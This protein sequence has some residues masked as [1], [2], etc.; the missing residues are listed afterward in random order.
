MTNVGI[1]FKRE[2][3]SYFS[4]PL[5]AIFIVIFLALSGVMTFYLGDFFNRGQ[6]D[7]QP[8]FFF[9]PWLYLFLIPAVT[10]RLWAEERKS[11]TIELLL[12]LPITT[13]DAVLGKFL[14]AW[15]FASCAMLLTFPLWLSVNYLGSPDNGAILAGYLGSLLMAGA[16]LAVGSF[17]SAF[18]KNQIIAFVLTTAA[19]FFFTAT[20]SSTFIGF[21]G[22]WAPN[23]FVDVLSGFSFITHFN[24]ISR[25]VLD[26][27][28][29]F[30]FITI[31]LAF[32]YFTAIVLDHKKAE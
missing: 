20:G 9:H 2:F 18:T 11:G 19:C 15:A 32:L 31:M 3:G 17:V 28:D 30:F 25:G 21:F 7:L 13:F 5:A 16:F 6:A 24:A 26:L 1:L 22:D 12:T 4:T 14:A 23:W 27:R 10:M 8:F 29:V